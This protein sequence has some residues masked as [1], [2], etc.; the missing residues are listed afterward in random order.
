MAPSCWK[1]ANPA[2]YIFT[3]LPD[4]IHI[5]IL[6]CPVLYETVS[7]RD[8]EDGTC[9]TIEIKFYLPNKC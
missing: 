4:G 8:F 1:W 3:K 5:L 6:A 9:K 2:D 7:K